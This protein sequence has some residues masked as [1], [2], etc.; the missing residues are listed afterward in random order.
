ME[1][2]ETIAALC[3]AQGPSGFEEKAASAAAELLRPL[4][5]ELHT[6]TLG[7]LIG[8]RRCGEENAPAVMLDAH[9]DQ[10]GL[11]VTGYEGRFLRFAPL[12][13][14]DPR[15]LPALEVELLTKS[16]PLPGVIDVL[17]PHVL[18]EAD[19][20]KPIP[21]DKLFIDAGFA[22]EEEA[23]AAVP[24]GTPACY[25]TPCFPLGEHQLCSRS[26]DDRSCVA[27]LL[28]VMERTR[29]K[30]LR[31]DVA[32]H[33]AVQEEV[34]GRGA[35]PG[36]YGIH[37]D[38]GV[39]LDVTFGNTPDA[40]RGTTLKMNGGAAIGVGPVMSRTISDRLETL[41]RERGIPYQIEVMGRTTG[42]DADEMQT[43]RE[44][45]AM[46]VISLP[47]KYMHS[48]VEV[49]DLRDAEAVT[50]LLCAWLETLGEED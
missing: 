37:P 5:D 28:A 23:R 47:L 49:I 46:G 16:G 14:V 2:R 13:G 18:S 44:G 12:G 7:N 15:I 32:V 24:Q 34:G 1:L 25:R 41:A 38:F 35:L 33:L 31:A 20:S 21:M 26:L 45:V 9:L 3:A 30:R 19:R 42:T 27:I 10:V 22:S 11:I 43:S 48:P 4:V 6:D 50:A 8:W 29:E 36:T 39:A 17:P 40:P